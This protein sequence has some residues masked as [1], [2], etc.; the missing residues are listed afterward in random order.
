MEVN[1]TAIIKLM[2]IHNLTDA[3]FAEKI[4]ISRVTMWRWMNGKTKADWS[5]IQKFK[6]AF[7]D[8]QFENFFKI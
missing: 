4:G 1:K 6:A 8:E 5:T 7:P 2:R 3:Q